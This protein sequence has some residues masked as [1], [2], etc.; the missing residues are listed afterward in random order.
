MTGELDRRALLDAQQFLEQMMKQ[1]QGAKGEKNARSGAPDE[2]RSKRRGAREKNHSSLP[3]KSRENKIKTRA[4]C[5][6]F[7]R[8][9]S[10]QVKGLLGAGESSGI[11]FKG[12]PTPGKSVAFASRNRRFLSSPGRAGA[13]FRAR[14]GSAQ[15]NDQE[16]FSCRWG[17]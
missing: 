6:S 4:R 13:Q 15:R 5:R 17:K 10:T 1:G 12:K 16:L 9:A 8:A 2:R 11:V 14:A 3:G 7:V